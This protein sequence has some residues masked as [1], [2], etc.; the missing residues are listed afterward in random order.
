MESLNTHSKIDEI[1]LAFLKGGITYEE[2]TM[3]KQ[4][5]DSDVSNKEY[6]RQIYVL[7]KSTGITS[8]S[9]DNTDKAFKQVYKHIAEQDVQPENYATGKSQFI[10]LVSTPFLKWAA[11]VLISLCTGALIHLGYQ[12]LDTN[13]VSDVAQN[14]I[15]VPM[16]SK[17]KIL[18][19]DKSEVWLNAGSRL[20]YPMTYGNKFREVNLI[21]E[22]YFKVAKMAN[23]PFIVHTSKAQIKAIGTEFNVKAYPDEKMVETILVKGIVAVR[24]TSDKETSKDFTTQNS[25]LLKPGQK[26]QIFKETDLSII[27]N[28]TNKNKFQNLQ[29]SENKLANTIVNLETSTIAVETSWKEPRWI[30]EGADLAHL[31]VELGRRFNVTISL[32]DN[33]LNKYQFSGIIQSE[34]IEEVFN[35]MSLTIPMSYTIDKGKVEIK[36]NTQLENK[37]KQAYK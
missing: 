15:I 33:G 14:E 31:F 17:S 36:L 32:T 18:L 20:T 34:T 23:K 29:K 4:W 5:I 1:I 30:I 7:W 12:R 22:G 21:G 28:Q 3:L 11:V 25:V 9:K 26:I 27:D 16:G 8:A 37:Y 13:R 10:Q 24:K 35:L 19:P 6:F 2:K